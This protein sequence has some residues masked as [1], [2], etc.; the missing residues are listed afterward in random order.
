[1]SEHGEHVLSHT[2][3]YMVAR[4]LPGLV[5]FAAIPLLTRY[6]DPAGYCRYAL[7]LG[8]VGLLNALGFQWLR[9]ALVRYLPGCLDDPAILKSTLVTA[10]VALLAVLG[11]MV[12]AVCFMP[13]G[14]EWKLIIAACWFM[15][16][17]QAM[18]DMCCE[19]VRATL[20][21][22][23]Y[24]VLQLVRSLATVGIGLGLIMLGLGWWGPILGGAAGMAG[25]VAW[26][27]RRDW[28]D[29]RIR[30]DRQSLAGICQYGLPLSLTIA[31]TLV[32]STSDR[33]LLTWLKGEDVGGLYSVAVDF[34]SQT[35]TLL[36]LV[37]NMAVFP[38][39]VRAFERE[40]VEAAKGRMRHNAALLLAL[41]VPC[42]VGLSVLAEGVCHCFIGPKYRVSCA[43]IMPLVALGAFLG[44]LKA[45]HFDAAFQFAHRTIY[46]VWIVLAAAVVNV[47]LNLL[48]IKPWGIR[49]AAG[50]SVAA[51]VVAIALT[52]WLGRRHFAMPFPIRGA[53]QVGAA[54]LLMGMMLYPLRQHQNAA[55]LGAQIVG[56]AAVYG[57][58]LVTGDFLGVRGA[59]VRRWRRQ[60]LGLELAAMA[61]DTGASVPATAGVG[62]GG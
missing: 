42:V 25:A 60:R 12:A 18:F 24:M 48:A 29:V 62:N 43:S 33:Y 41:G 49:G 37:V 27:Y 15:L 36:L 50:A 53:V 30:Y 57:I 45:Y 34:T 44:G 59:I 51:Y 11:F 23:K 2:A 8:G 54:A 32:F 31:L 9:L 7:V 35:L 10:A 17:A 13:V 5:A 14:G 3:I 6:L 38:L 4:G 16:A 47:A 46:Q 19:Y 58:V 61:A 21:P 1:M 22:W 52:A 56:G 55:A 40:G 26:T 39:A 20:R 28:S